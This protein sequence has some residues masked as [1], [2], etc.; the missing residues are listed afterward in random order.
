MRE[1]VGEKWSRTGRG[2]GLGKNAHVRKNKMRDF[3]EFFSRMNLQMMFHSNNNN[4]NN[5]SIN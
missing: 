1:G 2:R 4:N 5:N 3:L